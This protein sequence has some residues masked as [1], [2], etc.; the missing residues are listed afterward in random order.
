MQT[1]SWK[2]HLFVASFTGGM[3]TWRDLD[4]IR[5]TENVGCMN[6]YVYKAF[7]EMNAVVHSIHKPK[8]GN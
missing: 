7:I 6:T 5:A 3:T 2:H 4:H 1:K 8:I